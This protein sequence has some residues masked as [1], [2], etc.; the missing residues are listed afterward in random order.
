MPGKFKPKGIYLKNH[1][2]QLHH[3]DNS[4]QEYTL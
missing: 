2:Y 1:F 4:S 3:C